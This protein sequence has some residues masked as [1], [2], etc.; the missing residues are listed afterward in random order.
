MLVAGSYMAP[1]PPS[2]MRAGRGNNT[3]VTCWHKRVF[4]QPTLSRQTPLTSLA[5]VPGLHSVVGCT[6]S[7]RRSNGWAAHQVE[8]LLLLA[9]WHRQISSSE[10]LRSIFPRASTVPVSSRVQTF[11]SFHLTGMTPWIREVN[12]ISVGGKNKVETWNAEHLV[13]SHLQSDAEQNLRAYSHQESPLV[14][15]TESALLSYV[16][17]SGKHVQWHGRPQLGARSV[18]I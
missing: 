12:G 14:H 6:P 5:P 4:H 2:Q 16:N 15:W 18:A 7:S 9:V 8:Q 10:I 3:K 11:W 1:P 13:S 17:V